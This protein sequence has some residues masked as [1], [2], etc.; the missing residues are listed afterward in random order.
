VGKL[1][2]LGKCKGK[3]NGG[4]ADAT[5]PTRFSK[6]FQM[7]NEWISFCQ[8][9]RPDLDPY[10]T[11][12][13]FKD[14]WTSKPKDNTKLDWLATWRGWVRRQNKSHVTRQEKNMEGLH[15][16]TGGLLRPKQDYAVFPSIQSE[17]EDAHLLGH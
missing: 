5:K 7:T 6:D 1:K 11:F 10:K 3:G 4:V 13:D 8:N 16:L 2:G 17:I 12:D 15:Q 9:E 14:F